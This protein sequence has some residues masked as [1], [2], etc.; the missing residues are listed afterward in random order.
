M[1]N[2]A[3]VT[4]HHGKHIKRFGCRWNETVPFEMKEQRKLWLGLWIK[5]DWRIK[6]FSYFW[7]RIDVWRDNNIQLNGHSKRRPFLIRTRLREPYGGVFWDLKEHTS[8]SDFLKAISDYTRIDYRLSRQNNSDRPRKL[9]ELHNRISY[10]RSTK[11][12]KGFGNGRER[13]KTTRCM[14]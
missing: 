2:I 9:L 3:A 12:V 10:W 1:Y 11:Y 4:S 6:L 7:M 14:Q 13:S 5:K 8:L